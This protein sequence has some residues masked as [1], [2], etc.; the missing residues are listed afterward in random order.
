M[1]QSIH[2]YEHGKKRMV[3][4]FQGKRHSDATKKKMTASRKGRHWWNNGLKECFQKDRP[5]EEWVKG[6]L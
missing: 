3:A 1:L 2:A 5:N 6:R 4:P